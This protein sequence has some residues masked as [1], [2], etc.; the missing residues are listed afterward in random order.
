MKTVGAFEAKTHLSRLLH[1]V[2][3]H[4]KDITITLHNRSVAC[5]VPVD[6]VKKN[7]Q[8]AVDVVGGFKEIRRRAEGRGTLK[9]LIE[10][11]RKR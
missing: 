11:E 3:L 4:H 10:E 2:E 5:L 9:S 1:D 7:G 8:Q 6:H